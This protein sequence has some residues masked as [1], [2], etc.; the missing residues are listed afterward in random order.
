MLKKKK[1][2]WNLYFYKGKYRTDEGLKRALIKDG[3]VWV[4]PYRT[5][6]YI[7]RYF[8]VYLNRDEL[9]DYAVDYELTTEENFNKWLREQ[10]KDGQCEI[11]RTQW[12]HC[13]DNDGIGTCDWWDTRDVIIDSMD[14]FDP[15]H[16]D[17][18][19][20]MSERTLDEYCDTLSE[21]EYEKFNKLPENKQFRIA[22]KWRVDMYNKYIKNSCNP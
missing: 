9:R 10:V 21:E 17:D 2:L 14:C 22:M 19:I 3:I 11:C 1:E 8:G 15:K 20:E 13:D 7:E 6:Y 5:Y 4:S 16:P 18:F 12:Y